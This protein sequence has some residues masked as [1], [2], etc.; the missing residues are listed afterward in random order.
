LAGAR[1]QRS[2]SAV[3]VPFRTHHHWL[4]RVSSSASERCMSTASPRAIAN[5]AKKTLVRPIHALTPLSRPSFSLQS[6]SSQFNIPR[7]T[8]VSGFANSVMSGKHLALFDRH[9][10]NVR[11]TLQ[12]KRKLKLRIRS[13]NSMAT[14][15]RGSFGT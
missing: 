14:S 11:L 9:A 2:L 10:L 13:S 5:A 1:Q 15:R 7:R 6:P 4:L 3:A 12:G 8:F